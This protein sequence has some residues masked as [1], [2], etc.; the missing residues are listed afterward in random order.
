MNEIKPL[1]SIRELNK[2]YGDLHVL[3][4]IAL[5]V[6]P[7]EVVAIIGASGSGKSTFLRCLNV[8]EMPQSCFMDFGDFCFDFRE[9]ARAQPDAVQL[10]QLRTQIGM[11][12]QS[13]HLW[14]HMTVL[15]NVIEAPMRVKKMSRKVAIAE[16][17]ELLTRVGM[18]AKRDSYPAKLSG[19][20]QQRVAIARALAMKPKLMLFDEA[21]SAL[22]PELVGEVLSL[23][24]TLANDGMTMLLV[25]HEIAFAREVS[26]RVLFF[27]QGVIA[28]DGP[29]QDVLAKPKSPR[30]QQFL[31]RILHEDI[32]ASRESAQ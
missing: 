14:P 20:Q 28:E 13:Y 29:P 10:Q 17:D 27:D 19:G 7:G 25:T 21:T 6:M 15:E 30:L 24:A 32:T 8:M 23:I 16:A 18:L 12:F 5:E 22:D 2:S 26:N 31:R 4:N 11:V 9:G 3:K 1:L